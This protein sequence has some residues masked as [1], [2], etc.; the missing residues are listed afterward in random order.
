MRQRGMSLERRL[1][2]WA[3]WIVNGCNGRSGFASMLEMM[4]TTRCQFNGGGGEPK[5][6]IETGVEAAV[7]S[8]TAIDDSAAMVLRVEY[9]AWSYRCLDNAA[10]QIDKAHALSLSLRTYK[11][12]LAKARRHVAEY[13]CVDY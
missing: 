12:R 8:L 9:G 10:T 5:D 11:R 13:L 1:E 2:L 6:D 7:M 4:M 3:R